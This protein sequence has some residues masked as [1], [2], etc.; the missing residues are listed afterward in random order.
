[1]ESLGEAVA[2]SVLENQRLKY[3]E[4]FAAFTFTKSDGTSI[5]V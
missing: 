1:V 3:K 4:D 2:I 5:T